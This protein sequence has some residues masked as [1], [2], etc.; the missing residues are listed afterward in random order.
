MHVG[1]P[2]LEVLGYF[3]AK[4]CILSCLF[5]GLLFSRLLGLNFDA[6]DWKTEHL[7]RDVLHKSTFAQARFLMIPRSIFHDLGGLGT[8]FYD[9]CCP[10]DWPEI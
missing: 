4:E 1:I 2:Y 6:W 10:G 8:N 7:A 5:P 9:V 3:E